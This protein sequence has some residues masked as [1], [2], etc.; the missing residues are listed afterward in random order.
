MLA[1][2]TRRQQPSNLFRQG[3]PNISREG[4][5]SAKVQL[6]HKSDDPCFHK[7]HTGAGV[8]TFV[9]HCTGEWKRATLSRLCRRLITSHAGNLAAIT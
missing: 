5:R 6:G 9:A 3:H 2:V 7:K 8:M 4:I 1:T